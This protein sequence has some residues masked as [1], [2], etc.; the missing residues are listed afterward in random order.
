MSKERISE[1]SKMTKNR[2]GAHKFAN[3]EYVATA[4]SLELYID[5]TEWCTWFLFE[6]TWDLA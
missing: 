5:D 4:S 6:T 1:T 3:A 2:R